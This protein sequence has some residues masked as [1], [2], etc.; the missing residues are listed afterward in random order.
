MVPASGSYQPLGLIEVGSV[1]SALE[2]C[3]FVET[4]DDIVLG[5]DLHNLMILSFGYVGRRLSRQ[6][7]TI[8]IGFDVC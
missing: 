5:R 3:P 2:A 1:L 4:K 8:N 7:F 6:L